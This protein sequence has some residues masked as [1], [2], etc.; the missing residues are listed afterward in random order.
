MLDQIDGIVSN[1][2]GQ[3]ACGANNQGT[4]CGSFEVACVG[5][6]F[7]FWTLGSGLAIGCGIGT[8]FGKCS[9]LGFF[10]SGLFLQQCVQ[11]GQ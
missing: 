10:F 5:G 8:C 7:A 4:R 1:L 6:V 2:L 3:F 11:H 9:A